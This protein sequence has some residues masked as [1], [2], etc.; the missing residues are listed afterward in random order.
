MFEWNHLVKKRGFLMR[1]ILLFAALLSLTFLLAC[2]SSKTDEVEEHPNF[3]ITDAEKVD[4]DEVVM[5]LN[6]QEVHGDRYNLAYLQIKVQLFQYGQDVSK[7][8]D[9]Q[10]RAIEALVEQEVLLQDATEKGI[11]VTD[12]EIEDEMDLIKTESLDS[13]E[14]FLETYKFDEDSYKMMLS[15]AMLYDQYVKDQFPNI[16]VSEEE[17]EEAYDQLKSENEDLADLEDIK[18]SLRA[19]LIQQKENEK[20]QERLDSLKDQADIEVNI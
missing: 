4:P 10:E 6:G 1:K 3:D 11:E 20:V 18:D 13:F 5:H 16:D 19:G 14:A 12:A 15:F 9:I 17:I 8:E 2:G 7:L